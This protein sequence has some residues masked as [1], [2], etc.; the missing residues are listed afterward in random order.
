MKALFFVKEVLLR[1][2]QLILKSVMNEVRKLRV[3]VSS[4]KTR[5]EIDMNLSRQE[6]D[7]VTEEFAQ[8][9]TLSAQKKYIKEHHLD[10]EIRD[11]EESQLQIEEK[12][13]KKDEL[14]QSGK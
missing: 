4:V 5:K 10:I 13:E 14:Q 6:Y 12:E 7:K 9:K 8:L 3:K 11:K 1:F 2:L